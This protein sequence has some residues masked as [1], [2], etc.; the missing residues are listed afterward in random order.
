MTSVK[1]VLEIAD[2]LFGKVTFTKREKPRRKV[3]LIEDNPNDVLMMTD[4]LMKCGCQVTVAGNAEEARAIL[5]TDGFLIAFL[6][7]RLTHMQGSDLI[8]LIW[9]DT[10]K[11]H[12]VAIP[13]EYSDLVRIEKPTKAFSVL[14]KDSIRFETVLELLDRLK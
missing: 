7:M 11:V 3:L 10:P 9:R 5:R 1:W 8:H 14:T 4:L 6:D 13:G 2:W 12:V